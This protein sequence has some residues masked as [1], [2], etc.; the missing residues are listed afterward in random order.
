MSILEH[1]PKGYKLREVQRQTLLDVERNWDNADVFMLNL[2][3]AAGKS[4]IAMTIANWLKD[5]TSIIV[6]QIILQKVYEE[7]FNIPSVMGKSRYTCNDP[8]FELCEDRALL[9]GKSCKSC[10]Y[11]KALEKAIS[12]KTAVCNYHSYRSN[13]FLEGMAKPNL[14]IDEAHNYIRL[15]QDLYTSTLWEHIHKFPKNIHTKDGIIIWLETQ[16]KYLTKKV[17]GYTIL[18][19]LKY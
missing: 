9:Y 7:E 5:D 3:V 11:N 13:I 16:V 19:G 2:P 4:L 14:I 12:S 18:Q 6:P 1:V 17:A 10:E 15:L 8:E